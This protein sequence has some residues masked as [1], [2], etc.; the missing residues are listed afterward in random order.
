MIIKRTW[1]MPN[2]KT[3]TILPI[4]ELLLRYLHGTIVD[5]FAGDSE[6]K[7]ITND[8]NPEKNTKYHLD[9]LTFLKKMKNNMADV[10][11]FDPPYSITQAAKCYKHYGKEKLKRN[12]ANLGYWSDCKNEVARIIKPAGLAIF[13]GWNSNGLGKNRNFKMIEILLVVHGGSH[14]D[15]IV[16]VERKIGER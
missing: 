13:C 16:T 3:F 15:T 14:N 5:P 11:L 6:F 7:S 4:R 10:V 12:V 2:R 8:L 1:A 9:G